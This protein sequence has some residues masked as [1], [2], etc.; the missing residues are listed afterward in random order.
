MAIRTNIAA[1]A[2]DVDA[3]CRQDI[4]HFVAGPLARVAGDPSPPYGLDDPQF[5][6]LTCCPAPNNDDVSHVN[7]GSELRKMDVSVTY[8][9][10]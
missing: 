2:T 10:L 1:Q 6:K 3:D 4:Y 7:L 5:W 9:G 8:A